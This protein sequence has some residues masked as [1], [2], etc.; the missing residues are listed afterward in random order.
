MSAL[1]Q[2][3]IK[4]FGT[5]FLLFPVSGDVDVAGPAERHEF[6]VLEVRLHLN[7]VHVRRLGAIAQE[8][9]RKGRKEMQ[10]RIVQI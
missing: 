3:K 5:L 6:L 9:L 1:P 2:V 4:N 7:L 10:F 8:L